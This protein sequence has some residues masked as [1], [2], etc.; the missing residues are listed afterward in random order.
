MDDNTV[1]RVA[2]SICTTSGLL[3]HNPAEYWRQEA[4]RKR[5]LLLFDCAC[6]DW[7]PYLVGTCEINEPSDYDHDT[8]GGYA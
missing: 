1:T 7:S 3:L 6:D 2:L 4:E 5:E 8:L